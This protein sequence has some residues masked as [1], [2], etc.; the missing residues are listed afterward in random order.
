[1]NPQAA[2]VF[3]LPSVEEASI[4]V[5]ELNRCK[6]LLRRYE[7]ALKK[8][9]NRLGVAFRFVPTLRPCNVAAM[10]DSEKLTVC[11]SAEHAAPVPRRNWTDGRDQRVWEE[12]ELLRAAIDNKLVETPA[13]VV[14]FPAD[15][16]SRPEG[17]LQEALSNKAMKSV[18]ATGKLVPP[19]AIP[20]GF[21]NLGAH[22]STFLA[23]NL[24]IER[25]VFIMMRFKQNP[26]F[27]KMTAT[28][29]SVLA[30]FGLVA[31]RADDKAYTTDLWSNVAV[32]ML[33][34]KYGIAVFEDIDR[35]GFN[36]NVPLEYGFMQALDKKVLLLR[37]KSLKTLPSDVTG[38]LYKPFDSYEIETSIRAS[39]R[40]WIDHDLGLPSCEAARDFP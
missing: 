38:F 25:N 31:L 18:L 7:E 14:S 29:R 15:W 2:S 37:D 3:D 39:A 40:A 4:P 9:A 28:I 8:A 20:A 30:E 11:F 35:E 16:L 1:M 17:E 24:F 12:V 21:E 23:N 19:G 27:E 26:L 34:C 6:N 33:G 13:I 5:D 32:Y 10:L 22:V 36:P